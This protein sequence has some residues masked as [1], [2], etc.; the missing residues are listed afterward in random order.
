MVLGREPAN[1]PPRAEFDEERD[2]RME[3]QMQEA[4]AREQQ[5][6]SPDT[7]EAARLREGRLMREQLLQA[8][9]EDKVSFSWLQLKAG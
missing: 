9:A 7:A 8:L 1:L 5:S 2:A 6:S 4:M 3:Y